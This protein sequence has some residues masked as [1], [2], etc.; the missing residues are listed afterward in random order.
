MEKGIEKKIA[1]LIYDNKVE[2]GWNNVST[3]D[4]LRKAIDFLRIYELVKKNVALD[5]VMLI[6]GWKIY[7]PKDNES[8]V[9]TEDTRAATVVVVTDAPLLATVDIGAIVATD[10]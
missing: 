5:S 1:D 10:A 2:D 6:N 8:V 3:E 7:T 9:V 4:Y